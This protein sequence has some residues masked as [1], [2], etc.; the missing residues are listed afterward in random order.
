M[1]RAPLGA[2]SP[3]VNRID[4]VC[5]NAVYSFTRTAVAI[6]MPATKETYNE[7]VR[8]NYKGRQYDEMYGRELWKIHF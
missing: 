2:G 6:V 1:P 4:T 3:A 5:F 8:Y 7:K